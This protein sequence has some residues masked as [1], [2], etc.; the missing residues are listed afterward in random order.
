M[1][2]SLPRYLDG[3]S[4]L[5]FVSGLTGKLSALSRAMPL[6]CV[7][8]RVK[9]SKGLAFRRGGFPTVNSCRL[10]ASG[11]LSTHLK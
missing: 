9:P 7:V 4:P 6:V 3:L 5:T 1:G 11:G 8:R 10:R 2:H